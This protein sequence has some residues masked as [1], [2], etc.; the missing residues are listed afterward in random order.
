MD[1]DRGD[2][3]GSGALEKLATKLGAFL[4]DLRVVQSQQY[5]LSLAHLCHA[6]TQLAYDTWVNLFPQLWGVLSERQRQVSTSLPQLPP[7][8]SCSHSFHLCTGTPIYT[9]ES[10]TPL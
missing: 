5:L 3:S 8:P 7:S 6:D 10:R 9:P 1:S 4:S 2:G